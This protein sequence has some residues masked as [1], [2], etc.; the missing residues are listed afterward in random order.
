MYLVFPER[1]EDSQNLLLP[2]SAGKQ[3]GDPKE[4]GDDVHKDD[5]DVHEDD[6]DLPD[7]DVDGVHVDADA[8]VDGV[9]GRGSVVGGV[10]L[11]LVDDLLGVVQQ[12]GSELGGGKVHKDGTVIWENLGK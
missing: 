12:E 1:A 4:D 10:A 3:L 7:E 6:D 5:E 11:G 8:G 2:A 9:E